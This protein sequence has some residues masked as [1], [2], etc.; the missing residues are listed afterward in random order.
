MRRRYLVL[1]A[2]AFAADKTY[3]FI[4]ERSILANNRLIEGFISETPHPIRIAPL[5]DFCK[6][7]GGWGPYQYKL[8]MHLDSIP[9]GCQIPTFGV[10]YLP[11]TGLF[12][13]YTEKYYQEELRFRV[14]ILKIDSNGNVCR[15]YR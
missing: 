4:L 12:S 1:L 8:C 13:F 5:G 3:L 15:D 6:T 2:L 10:Q 11:P 9:P 14:W 7:A